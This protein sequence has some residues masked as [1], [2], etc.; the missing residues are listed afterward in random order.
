MKYAAEVFGSVLPVLEKTGVVLALEPLSPRTTTFLSTAAEAVELI[1][2]VDSPQC[3]LILDCNA[4]ST[5][6]APAPELICKYCSLLV[7]L[8]ANDPNGQGPG[9]GRLDF[10]PIFEALRQIDYRGWVS[11][12][13]FDY[14]PGVERLVRESIRNMQK[15]L[16]RSG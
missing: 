11:V 7:H 4:M 10:V 15:C 13:V 5:E 3:R 14:A 1:H 8:H 12:E 9:F 6:S 2:K 16:A